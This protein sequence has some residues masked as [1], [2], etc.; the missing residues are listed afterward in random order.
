MEN[1]IIL[2]ITPEQNEAISCT[3]KELAIEG[4]FIKTGLHVTLVC[5]E[6][7]PLPCICTMAYQLGIT[8]LKS[9]FCTLEYYHA[10]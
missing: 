8:N 4:I 2:K 3:G 1:N 5:E 6:K 9:I 7:E 10:Q